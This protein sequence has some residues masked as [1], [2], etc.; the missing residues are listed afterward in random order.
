M[1]KRVAKLAILLGWLGVGLGAA[2]TICG[3]LA[4]K[5]RH[6]ELFDIA[7]LALFGLAAGGLIAIVSGL[8][9]LFTGKR[10]QGACIGL[11]G[12]C[13]LLFA[14]F[15]VSFAAAPPVGSIPS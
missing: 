7:V 10:L 15:V 5:S 14:T 13:L 9:A 3:L 12:L 2:S 4:L 1:K 11:S 6:D 8:V